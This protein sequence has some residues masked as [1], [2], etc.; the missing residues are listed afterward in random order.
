MLDGFFQPET[1]DLARFRRVPKFENPAFYSELEAVGK[2]VPMD[3][4]TP[5]GLTF[6]DTVLINEKY[7]SAS[8]PIPLIFHELIHVVQ[9]RFI[10]AA[11]FVQKYIEGRIKDKLSYEEVPLERKTLELSRRFY[12]DNSAVFSIE[13]E[14]HA[15]MKALGYIQQ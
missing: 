10:G 5:H 4:T 6:I 7:V 9:F 3:F 8:N 12:K 13:T 2:S 14:I 15:D 1:L 11:V